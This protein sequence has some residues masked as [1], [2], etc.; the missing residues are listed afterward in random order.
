MI[1]LDDSSF[2]LL[3]VEGNVSVPPFDCGDADLNEFVM[4]DALKYS[5]ELLAVTYAFVSR[6][7]NLLAAFYSVANDKV[8]HEDARRVMSNTRHRNFFRTLLPF[9]K[10]SRDIPAVKI[11]R[12]GVHRDF[13]GKNIGS[14]LLTYIKVAFA[15]KNK[16]GCRF[17]TVDAYNSPGTLKFYL[18]NGFVFFSDSDESP[19][20]YKTRLMYFDLAEI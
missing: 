6:Q 8:T 2:R 15:V 14:Q 4:V 12:L 16:T 5:A 13:Q 9:E 7:K 11:G 20:R 3:R 18:N 17:I 1:L 10:R 19:Q